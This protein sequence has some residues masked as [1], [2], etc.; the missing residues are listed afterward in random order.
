MRTLFVILA[1]IGGTPL[2]ARGQTVALHGEGLDLS[3]QVKGGDDRSVSSQ[4]DLTGRL[5]TLQTRV[6]VG[7]QSGSAASAGA[8]AYGTGWWNSGKVGVAATWAPT[9]LAK[10]DLSAQDSLRLQVSTADPIWTDAAQRYNTSR[11]SQAQASA[12]F[13]PVS[14][15]NLQVGAATSG[16][17]VLDSARTGAGQSYSDLLQTQ[18][19]QIFT[20]VQWKPL[21]RI[22]LEGGGRVESTGVYW[23][24]ARAGSFA[25]VN[26]SAGA[27]LTPW[28]G[29]AWRLSVEGAAAPLSTDQFIGYGAGVATPAGAGLML[30]PNREWR[31]RAALQQKA[32]SI[33]LTASVLHA[34]LQTYN[35]VA[36]SP[37]DAGRVDMGVGQRSE[38]Q[39]AVAAPIPFYGVLPITLRASGAWRASRA[40]DPLT[41]V[42]G[43]LSGEAPY[44]ASLSLTQTA[45]AWNMRW[46][47]T[48]LASGPART[49]LASQ[50]SSRSASAGLGG[51][52]EYR[53]G[54][55]TLQLHL[56]NLLGGDRDQREVYYAGT[57]D[58][59]VVDRIDQV[60]ASDRAI[61]F[62]LIRPL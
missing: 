52:F 18:A 17:T 53:P 22:S 41:G 28:T 7:M 13:T 26:P 35:Y 59:N 20:R 50:V 54:P 33:D 19:Q 16:S 34:R 62:S 31:W 43:R 37:G 11:Q 10:I 58:L 24:G 29:A 5:S 57:R 44:D 46:G 55:V 23:A 38:V 15:L 3:M 36:P 21:N 8:P 6:Q 42:V 27:T 9:S 30:Q 40:A 4:A 32:G 51:F 39:A 1:L 60:R 25:M 48:A 49:Y 61:R 14:P 12:T 56:D 47:M 2:A 45:K